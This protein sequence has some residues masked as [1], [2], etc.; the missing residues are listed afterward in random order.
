MWNCN[1]SHLNMGKCNLVWYLIVNHKEL[2]NF[3]K[4]KKRQYIQFHINSFSITFM[5][6]SDD[7]MS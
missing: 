7:N 5:S 2:I 4:L 3:Y 1:F 6:Y